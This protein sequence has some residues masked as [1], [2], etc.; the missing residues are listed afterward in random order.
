M[1]YSQQSYKCAVPNCG[2][3]SIASRSLER[4][5]IGAISARISATPSLSE[6]PEQ[7]IPAI[8]PL[9][10]AADE[11]RQQLLQLFSDGLISHEEVMTSLTRV[12][13]LDHAR[14]V[15][16]R[17]SLTAHRSAKSVASA[18]ANWVSLVD[19]V[20]DGDLDAIAE[21][22]ESFSALLSRVVISRAEN[23][24]RNGPRIDPT[25]VQLVWKLAEH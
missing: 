7:F 11:R 4:L 24:K 16:L 1:G 21:V 12:D 20:S 15:A 23:G 13:N 8:D 5:V 17:E 22:R 3:V 19:L 18:A 2:Q 9:A 14:Q 6:D 10:K 25:R